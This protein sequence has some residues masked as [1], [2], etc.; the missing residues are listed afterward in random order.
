MKRVLCFGS[1]NLD[2]V[3]SVEHFAKPG[4]TVSAD[5][6]AV[7]EGGKGLNQAVAAA[8]AGSEVSMAGAVS[9]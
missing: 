6:F 2:Y 5:A 3:Y 7:F 8:L 9:G 4:E 1:L